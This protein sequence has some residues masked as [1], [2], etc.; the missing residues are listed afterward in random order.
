MNFS[1]TKLGKELETR[2]LHCEN[3][4]P[5]LLAVSHGIVRHHEIALL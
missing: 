4:S 5:F 3:T 1:E 2:L